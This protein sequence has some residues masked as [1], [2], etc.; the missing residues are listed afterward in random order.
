MLKLIKSPKFPVVL[1]T[2]LLFIIPFFW[3]KP[4]QIDIGGDSTRLYF[5]DP[6]NFLINNSLYLS[7]TITLT[8]RSFWPQ[9]YTLPYVLMLLLIKSV[10]NSPYFLVSL[11][12][13]IKVSVSFLSVYLIVRMILQNSYKEKKDLF[14]QL[15]AVLGGLLYTTAPI[16]IGNYDKALISHDQIFLNPLCFY[17]LLCYFIKQKFRYLFAFLI[18][19]VIFASNFSWAA[20]PPLFTFYPLILLFLFFYVIFI[21][22]KR[23][24]YRHLFIAVFLFLGFHAF[25]FLPEAYS[26]LSPNSYFS[27][28]VFGQ[29][30]VQDDLNYFFG[31]LPLAKLSFNILLYLPFKQYI[32]LS[33]VPA[34]FLFLGLCFNRNKDKVLFLTGIFFLISLFLVTAN[35]TQTGVNLYTL[36]FYIPGFSMFRN[37]I[38][39]WAFVYSFFYALLFGQVLYFLFKR[40][41]SIK[42]SIFIAVFISISLIL[43]NLNFFKG[44]MVNATLDQSNVRI[45]MMVDPQY[46]QT[47]SYIRSL[48]NEGAFI[49]F[50]FTDCCYTVVHGLDNGAY[51]GPSPITTLT[52]KL[53]Y[54]GYQR[55]SPFGEVFFKLVKDKNYVGIKKLLGLLNIR[56]IYYNDNPKVYDITFPESPYSYSRTAFPSTQVA[57]KEFIKRIAG[58]EIY[59]K[60]TYH[61]YETDKSYFHPEFYA[62]DYLAIYK[63]LQ[64]ELYNLKE[65]F[66]DFSSQTKDVFIDKI[67]CLKIFSKTICNEKNNRLNENPSLQFS[68]IN[69]TMYKVHVSNARR[70]Y[71][72]V[73]SDSFHPHWELSLSRKTS[74]GDIW[75]PDMLPE[76][77]IFVNGYANAWYILPKDV[78]N[79]SDY[80]L[81]IQMSDQKMFY[82]GAG[83]S[84]ITLLLA[85]IFSIF[86]LFRR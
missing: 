29:S 18:I 25:H 41:R 22:K 59:H 77:Q 34:F 74:N 35:I 55:I 21:L 58:K 56:Y 20:A 78:G 1:I 85:A 42:I 4:G 66:F 83:V 47:L 16:V 30:V 39:Q 75:N 10:I 62:V 84:I 6:L 46:E 5:Y 23:V 14:L 48:K 24:I 37:F 9:F 26:L 8:S 32:F 27:Q 2:I 44:E 17:L 38:G 50:P 3:L 52:G 61:I 51:I 45:P 60:G 19:T 64:T 65:P 70:P 53:D 69:S 33:I 73:F 67:S 40:I 43:T 7:E 71:L 80:T 57:Y 49:S 86:F 36:F 79:K 81:T 28:R 76:R 68:K 11:F 54:D 72:L 15:P 13:G 82:I 63:P 12:N 31:V